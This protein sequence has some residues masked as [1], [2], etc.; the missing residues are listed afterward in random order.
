MSTCA[1][2]MSPGH[3]SVRQVESVTLEKVH[4]CACK[5]H[6]CACKVHACAC[7]V[8]GADP[9]GS[10]GCSSTPLAWKNY[11]SVSHSLAD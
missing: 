8:P 6:A 9:A 7:M 1:V 3:V 10:R 11:L 5:V 4:A 2:S